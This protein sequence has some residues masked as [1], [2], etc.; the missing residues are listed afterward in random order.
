MSVLFDMES[1]TS[2]VLLVGIVWK[3]EYFFRL[4]RAGQLNGWVPLVHLARIVKWKWNS[5][6]TLSKSQVIE[7]VNVR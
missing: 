2:L 4:K 3:C 7:N 5:S 1:E 6:N